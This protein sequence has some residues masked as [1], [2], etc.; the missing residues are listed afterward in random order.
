[1]FPILVVEVTAQTVPSKDSQIAVN[2]DEKLCL[3]NIVFLG[4]PMQERRRGV[5]PTAAEHI[6]L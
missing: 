4:E 1:M 2:I 3:G 5:N 6:H